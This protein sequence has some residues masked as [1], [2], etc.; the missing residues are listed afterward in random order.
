[1]VAKQMTNI[2]PILRNRL[3]KDKCKERTD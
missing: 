2:K 1:M 3:Y